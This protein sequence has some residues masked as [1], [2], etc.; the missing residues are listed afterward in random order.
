MKK[1]SAKSL[2]ARAALIVAIGAGGVIP[3][4]DIAS[5]SLGDCNSGRVCLWASPNFVGTT[6]AQYSSTTGVIS[7]NAQSRFNK[8]T[9]CAAYYGSSGLIA[10]GA[11]N[12]GWGSGAHTYTTI[13]ITTC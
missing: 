5:A 6:S 3:S 10:T 11:P 7:V 8:T 13:A 2:A 9:K 4:H 1:P 12:T